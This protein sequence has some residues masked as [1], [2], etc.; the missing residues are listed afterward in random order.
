M[1]TLFNDRLTSSKG[2]VTFPGFE[3]LRKTLGLQLDTVLQYQRQNP[4]AVPSDHLLVRILQSLNV[5]LDLDVNIYRDLVDDASGPLSMGLKLTSPLSPGR[6][7][8]PGV[9]YGKGSPE[10]WMSVTS[11][12]NYAEATRNWMN[13]CPVRFLSHP[14]TDLSLNVPMGVQNSDEVGL[15]IV[16]VDI[17]LLAFQYRQWRLRER[18][19]NPEAQLT[20]M[21]FVA[22]YPLPNSL[23]SQLD[24][25]VF[26]RMSKLYVDNPVGVSRLSHPFLLVD[27][28]RDVDR[29]LGMMLTNY[30]NRPTNWDQLLE[31]FL[32]PSGRSYRD[33]IRLPDGVQ[34][35]QVIWALTLARL[36]VL[37]FLLL[38]SHNTNNQMNGIPTNLI[39]KSLQALKSNNALQA[40]LPRPLF[41]SVTNVI[42]TTILPYV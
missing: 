31:G 29:V 6:I 25:A 40:A 22:Q 9:L 33:V 27:H 34:N 3:Y 12:I 2:V 4:R 37:G 1:Y 30:E 41:Q 28:S 39:R 16:T 15:S 20:T 5:S 10:V 18:L 13:L 24:I 14:K 35:R 23:H 38:L 32:C 17:P 8:Y 42:N 7:R 26:N 21:H 19:V 11:R 36:N